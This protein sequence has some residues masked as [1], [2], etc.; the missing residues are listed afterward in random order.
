MRLKMKTKRKIVIVVI[1]IAIIVAIGIGVY[2][3]LS[4]HLFTLDGKVVQDGYDELIDRIKSMQDGETK[5]EV[6]ELFQNVIKPEDL[7]SL[8]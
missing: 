1:V 6:I 2:S 4:A 8:Y 5:N 7:N 3:V